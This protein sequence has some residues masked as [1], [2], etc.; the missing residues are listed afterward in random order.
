MAGYDKLAAMIGAQRS[1]AIFRRFSTLNAKSLLYMQAELM[2]LEGELADIVKEDM[3]S[4]EADREPFTWSVWHLKES[5]NRPGRSDWM[6]HP[7]GGNFF[8]KGR[9][10]QIWSTARPDELVALSTLSSRHGE[11]DGF[12]AWM[13]GRLVP[14]FHRHG[15]HQLKVSVT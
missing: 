8:L 9:E 10:A 2:H 12:T 5:I 3:T 14:W 1:L 11:C 13:H 15:A 7:D 4:G 6:E